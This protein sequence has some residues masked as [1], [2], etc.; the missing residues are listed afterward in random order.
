MTQLRVSDPPLFPNRPPLPSGTSVYQ[1]LSTDH[2]P[3]TEVNSDLQARQ[4]LGFSGVVDLWQ[5][6]RWARSVALPGQPL[7]GYTT[8][9][10]EVSWDAGLQAMPR[11]QVTVAALPAEQCQL[12][13]NLRGVTDAPGRVPWPAG[14]AQLQ[15]ARFTGVLAAGPRV[16]VW[17]AG[18]PVAGEAPAAGDDP[19]AF[20]L[21][22]VENRDDILAFWQDVYGRAAQQVPMAD[23][24][25]LATN[26]LMNTYPALD[27][28]G[29]EIVWQGGA[30]SV[31]PDVTIPELREALAAALQFVLS[32]GAV[33]LADLPIGHLRDRAEWAHLEPQPA[34]RAE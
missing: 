10:Q 29:M 14:R 25:P 4:V 26:A 27:P 28:F 5:G 6:P 20:M 19:V 11:A 7:L 1:N 34:G 16:S 32:R 15:A 8:G 13:W 2:Y 18:A 3:W 21:P 24:W 31:D 23:L 9:G 33:R 12:L 17:Q 30:L 22:V